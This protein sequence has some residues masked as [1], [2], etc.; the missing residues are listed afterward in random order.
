MVIFNSYVSHYQRVSIPA[1]GN[2]LFGPFETLELRPGYLDDIELGLFSPCGWET[3]S[4][5]EELPAT[6][7]PES[8]TI[9]LWLLNCYPKIQSHSEVMIIKH[10]QSPIESFPN[11]KS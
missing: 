3:L 11:D 2:L 8:Q 1:K 5:S 4:G 7:P 9:Q 10:D 6:I